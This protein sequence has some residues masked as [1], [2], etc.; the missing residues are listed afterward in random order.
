MACEAGYKPHEADHHTIHDIQIAIE[1]DFNKE[2][3]KLR[4]TRIV[5]HTIVCANWGKGNPPSAEKFMP[6]P[7]DKGL[8]KKR[9]SPM[10]IIREYERKKKLQQ[11]SNPPS[12]AP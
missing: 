11:Y 4:R 5:A 2:L 7:G 1:A 9:K 3:Q 12:P 10:E 8:R 6:L